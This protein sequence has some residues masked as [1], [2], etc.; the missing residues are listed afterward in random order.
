[1]ENNKKLVG[2]ILATGLMSFAGV[3]IE[4]AMN[5]TFP[6]LIQ[7]F[8]ITTSDV[9][10][11]TTIYLL[12]ISIIVPISTFLLKRFQL[13]TLFLAANMFF[14]AG[15]VIDF[16][17]PTF[18]I[19]LLGRLFQGAST[20]IAL[21][22]M[23]HIILTY[24]PYEKRGATI[25]LGNLTTS[26]APAI[27]PTYGGLLTAHWSW[28][29]IFLFLIPVIVI[30]LF[31]GLSSIP[32]NT[33]PKNATLDVLSVLSIVMLF[34]GFLLFLNQLGTIASLVPL[35][36]GFM[37]LGLFWQRAK[38]PHPLIRLD[39]LKN[40]S[41]C[42]FLFGFLVCQFLLLGVSFVLPNFV[43][44]VLG[45]DAFTAGLIMLPGA[46][47]GAILAPIAGRLLDKVGPK[48]PILLGMVLIV[49]GWLALALLLR[50]IFIW[51]L[52]AGHI[53]YMIGIGLSYSNMMTT[54]LNKL[55]PESYADGNAIFNTLQQFS[56][57]V[58]TAIVATIINL[59][60]SNA[61]YLQGT[62]IGSQIAMF[63]LWALVLLILFFMLH[64]F[65]RPKTMTK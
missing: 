19:L 32:K 48:K 9:Q 64:Y 16:L 51:G 43:Q 40:R 12:V 23:F 45:K 63:V 33:A 46:A 21:P 30:S 20:G 7:Q 41:F 62:I 11:V 10:W 54:G 17:S 14:L 37:G 53:F 24:S 25:G 28:N 3:L 47:I 50:S 57:A 18:A 13:R 38:G 1:M 58:A 55:T 65:F 61:G 42:L 44:I 5:V 59:A 27:G 26:I 2:A 34:S 56:G 36:V 6:T 8:G 60:Q 31:L 39:V 49:I 15:L 35:V 4:T 52:V 22:L 29:A